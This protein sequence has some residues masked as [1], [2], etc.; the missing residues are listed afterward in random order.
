MKK[1]M[2]L[3]L[4]LLLTAPM[5]A[6]KVMQVHSHG[7]IVYAI[8]TAQVDSI[9]FRTDDPPFD[10]ELIGVWVCEPQ[11]DV[12]ITLTIDKM[13]RAYVSTSP[14]DLNHVPDPTIPCSP[15]FPDCVVYNSYFCLVDGAQFVIRGDNMYW[16]DNLYDH[17]DCYK[18]IKLSSNSIK[19]KFMG[20]RPAD[21]TLVYDY[22]F[23]RKTD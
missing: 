5:W 1:I 12:T 21:P 8:P 19:A 18:I 17:T 7:D 4:I 9:T 15:F 13:Q 20:N 6:Q 16:P 23:N 10:N 11:T 3:T 14:Q 22:E 2:F